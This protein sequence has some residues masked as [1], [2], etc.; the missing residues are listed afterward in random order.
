M[1]VFA[2]GPLKCLSKLAHKPNRIPLVSLT[3]MTAVAA[4]VA[5]KI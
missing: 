3:F 1:W 4:E 2:L 5:A